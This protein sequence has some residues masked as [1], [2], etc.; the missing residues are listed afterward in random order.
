MV[1]SVLH[2]RMKADEEAYYHNIVNL[3]DLVY[4]YDLSYKVEEP[5]FLLVSL[6][7][8]DKFCINGECIII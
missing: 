5:T 6:S 2:N 4:V 8:L 1:V 7:K 3:N